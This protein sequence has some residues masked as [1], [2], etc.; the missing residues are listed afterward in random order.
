MLDAL[1]ELLDSSEDLYAFAL[2][3]N[4]W[5]FDKLA[6]L[7]TLAIHHEYGLSDVRVLRGSA[8]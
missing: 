3:D 8:V 6:H 1:A 4:R 7:G 2:S 5:V